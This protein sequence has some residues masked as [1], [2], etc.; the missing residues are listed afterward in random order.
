MSTWPARRFSL[1]WST[2][3]PWDSAQAS[4]P[5]AAPVP[6]L[7]KAPRRKAVISHPT[8]QGTPR[9]LRGSHLALG[10][11]SLSCPAEPRVHGLALILIVD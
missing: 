10:H 2:T 8:Q 3:A 9:A 4:A 11:I 5:K 6:G 7:G 1:A